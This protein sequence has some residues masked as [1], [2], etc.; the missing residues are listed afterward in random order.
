MIA[1]VALIA[2]TMTIETTT[3]TIIIAKAIEQVAI[4]MTTT[5]IAMTIIM[6]ITEASATDQTGIAVAMGLPQQY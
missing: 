5:S 6:T 3:M 1:T 2:M 4:E